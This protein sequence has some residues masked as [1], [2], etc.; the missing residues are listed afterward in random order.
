MRGFFDRLG[1]PGTAWRSPVLLALLLIV[2]IIFHGLATHAGE[3]FGGRVLH[4]LS[5]LGVAAATVRS[6]RKHRVLP[7]PPP[8]LI[9]MPPVG[10][11]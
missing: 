1:Y 2:D 9:A 6:G 8:A 7:L 3:T 10:T 4:D 5:L 11:E